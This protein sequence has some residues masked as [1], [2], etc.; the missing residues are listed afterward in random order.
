MIFAGEGDKIYDHPELQMVGRS[1]RHFVLPQPADLI[2]LPPDS[3]LFTVPGR[4]PV[5]WDPHRKTLVEFNQVR[6]GNRTVRPTAVSGFL[7]PGYLRLLLPATSEPRGSKPLPMWAYCAMGWRDNDFCTAAVLVEDNPRWNPANYD[8]KGLQD[9]VREVLHAHPE[10]RLF[11]HLARCATQYHCFAAKNLFWSRWEAGLPVSQNCN[12]HCLGCLSHQP[13]D[14]CQS[15]HERIEFQPSVQEIVEVAVPHLETAEAPM[16]S[17]GQGCEGEP[18]TETPLVEQAIRRIRDKT[19]R[20]TI[21]MNTNGSMP[22]SLERLCKAGL[23]S[24]RIS[25]NSTRED[26]YN[27]YYQPSGY[28]LE[29]VVE[30]IHRAKQCNLFVHINLLVF[31][32]ITDQPQEIAGLTT[33]IEDTRIDVLQLKNL[34]IDPDYYLNQMPDSQDQGIGLMKMITDLS[35]QFPRLRLGYFNIPKEEFL[36]SPE[37]E[38]NSRNTGSASL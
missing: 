6:M 2:P 1:G 19:P 9:R 17:F 15:S 25:V 27:A 22:R 5:G 32:G 35:K 28:R 4:H 18:L 13:I 36:S 37:P 24:I 14:S 8:D 31:P 38:P 10:N 33:L 11:R 7:P 20:G 12:A 30:S 34:N 16:V 26:R 21:H 3:K 29:D 23:N